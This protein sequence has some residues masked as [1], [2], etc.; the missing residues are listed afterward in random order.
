MVP[1][2]YVVWEACQ[3]HEKVKITLIT[4][5]ASSGSSEVSALRFR[6]STGRLS[7][8]TFAQKETAYSSSRPWIPDGF[9][10]EHSL[11]KMYDEL[12]RQEPRQPTTPPLDD[13]SGVRT[14]HGWATA[15][16]CEP[17]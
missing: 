12:G 4:Q 10:N 7:P 9:P 17:S 16:D 5:T 11:A 13:F 8:D 14:F 6:P 3:A 1:R 2:I 15:G